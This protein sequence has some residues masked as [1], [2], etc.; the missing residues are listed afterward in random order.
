MSERVIIIEVIY[1]RGNHH[2]KCQKLTFNSK[3]EIIHFYETIDKETLYNADIVVD[4][5]I[6][7]LFLEDYLYF[8]YKGEVLH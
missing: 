7:R 2:E 5:G 1:Y 6:Y 3:N 8:I 4:D